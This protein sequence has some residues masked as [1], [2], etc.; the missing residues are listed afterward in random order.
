ME[1]IIPSSLRAIW[2][3]LSPGCVRFFCIYDE[4]NLCIHKY[5]AF[6]IT[7]GDFVRVQCCVYSFARVLCQKLWHARDFSGECY[8]MFRRI[9]GAAWDFFVVDVVGLILCV[10]L[11]NFA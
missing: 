5:V 6:T 7:G 10:S 1:F 3:S 9:I 8:V 11:G 2:N 4:T